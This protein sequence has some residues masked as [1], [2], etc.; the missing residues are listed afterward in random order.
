MNKYK[1]Y[2]ASQVADVN[3]HSGEVASFKKRENNLSDQISEVIE[4]L[5]FQ[6]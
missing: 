2:R 5:N 4:W 6:K 3:I 1:S